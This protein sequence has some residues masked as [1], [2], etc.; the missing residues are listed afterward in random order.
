MEP[1]K[2]SVYADLTPTLKIKRLFP[3]NHRLTKDKKKSNNTKIKRKGK[4]VR[5]EM[6]KIVF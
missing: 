6:P 2:D 4:E 5:K 3:I 1:K